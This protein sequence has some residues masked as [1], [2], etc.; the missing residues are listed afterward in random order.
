MKPVYWI[1]GILFGGILFVL[2]FISYF[3]SIPD[4]LDSNQSTEEQSVNENS[5]QS[6]EEDGF[7]EKLQR[8]E[9]ITNLSV[10]SD[11]YAEFLGLTE[12]GV[13]NMKDRSGGINL[14]NGHYALV[15]KEI[16][17]FPGPETCLIVVDLI[18]SDGCTDA[19]WVQIGDEYILCPSIQV[20]HEIDD[21][22]QAGRYSYYTY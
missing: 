9:K 1:G 3:N 22:I 7:L 12:V 20:V 16:G 2:L 13:R 11:G 5:S 15:A 21:D 19:S 4:R 18:H 6:L 8:L 10:Q 17:Q 14:D